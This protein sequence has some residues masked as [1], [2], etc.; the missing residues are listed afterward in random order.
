MLT[1]KKFL[2]WKHRQSSEYLDKI[3]FSSDERIILGVLRVI[4]QLDFES[5]SIACDISPENLEF[6]LDHLAALHIVD[7]FENRFQVAPA[8]RTAVERDVRSQLSKDRLQKAT[9]A[10]SESLNIRIEEGSAPFQL[11]DAAVLASIESG[12][13]ASEFVGGFILPSHHAWLSKHHYDNRNWEESIRYGKEAIK[14][15]KRLSISGFVSACRYVCLASARLNRAD[16]F[17]EAIS[18]LENNAKD[19]WARSNV[20]YLKGFRLRNKGNLPAAEELFKESY[21]FSPGNHSA[22]RELAAISLARGNVADAEAFA[23][24]ALGHSPRNPYLVD[25]LLSVLMQ[26][27]GIGSVHNSE[28]EGLFEVLERVGESEGRSFYTTRRA[29]FEYITGD[30]GKALHFIKMAIEKTPTLFE[31]QRLYASILLKSGN[32][33]KAFEV[34]EKMKNIVMYDEKFDRKFNYR[35]Y[36][37]SLSEYYSEVGKFLEAKKLFNDYNVFTSAERERFVKSLETTESYRKKT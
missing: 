34:I 29:E 33:S 25:V 31:P 21:N 17:D 7:A 3:D 8:L 22:L 15:R 28:I 19:D 27:H 9:K 30:N 6:S 20:S 11:I 26:K 37:V 2:D 1:Q 16:I 4:P 10:I 12:V 23:R 18:E 13:I 32:K 24:E 36:L 5:L 14:G 35:S